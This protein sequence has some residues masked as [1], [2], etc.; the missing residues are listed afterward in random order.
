MHTQILLCLLI[1]VLSL[2]ISVY[3]EG[4]SLGEGPV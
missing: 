4:A 3:V 1:S 2:K